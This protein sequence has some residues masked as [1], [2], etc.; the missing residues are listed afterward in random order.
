[1]LNTLSDDHNGNVVEDQEEGVDNANDSGDDNEDFEEELVLDDRQKYKMVTPIVMRIG[2]LIACHP[3]KKFLQYLDALNELEKRIRRGQNFTLQL[4]HILA[5]I[6]DD[7]DDEGVGNIDHNGET[8]DSVVTEDDEVDMNDSQAT[9]VQEED[10]GKPRAS[11]S[12]GRFDLVFKQ[13]LKTKGRPKKKSKQCWMTN[14]M[15]QVEEMVKPENR[16]IY[17]KP[18][19]FLP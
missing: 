16:V 6:N 13:S 14:Q 11:T 9:V 19:D 4:H 15:K 18:E 17:R 8:R 5:D 3:T 10:G 12:R 1:M 2:N 7:S